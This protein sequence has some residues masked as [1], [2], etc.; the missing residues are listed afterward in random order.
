MT[1]WERYHSYNAKISEPL[2]VDFLE[3]VNKNETRSF[4]L[5]RLSYL[6]Q[7]P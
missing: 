5:N 2:K 7:V 1:I 4:F 6:Y 3:I